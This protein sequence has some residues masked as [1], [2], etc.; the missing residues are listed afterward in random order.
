MFF[1]GLALFYFIL[2][3]CYVIVEVIILFVVTEILY[4]VIDFSVLFVF[5]YGMFAEI[6]GY[7]CEFRG[8]C[9]VCS[10]LDLC[11][12]LMVLCFVYVCVKCSDEWGVCRSWYQKVKLEVMM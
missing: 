3:Y 4:W 9:I 11:F 5:V 7:F 2:F 10:Y 8:N 1:H 6:V 12:R